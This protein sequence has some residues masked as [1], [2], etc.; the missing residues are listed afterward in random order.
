MKLAY[1]SIF[2]EVFSLSKVDWW[3]FFKQNGNNCI[4]KQLDLHCD[5][6][7]SKD[8]TKQQRK[9]KWK[10]NKGLDFKQFNSICS[11]FRFYSFFI[12]IFS[13]HILIKQLVSCLT[14][15][16]KLYVNNVKMHLIS[17]HMRVVV[18]F[19]APV[20]F[21]L[22]SSL[23]SGTLL[24]CLFLKF[25]AKNTNYQYQHVVCKVKSR[26]IISRNTPKW[27]HSSF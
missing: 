4:E 16:E 21:L 7:R 14:D 5:H 1:D 27:F 3:W 20:S 26:P 23:V 25:Y 24:F 10:R 15:L 18:G 9:K 6:K 11:F 13:Y 2:F 8:W 19:G 12:V 22:F 17:L